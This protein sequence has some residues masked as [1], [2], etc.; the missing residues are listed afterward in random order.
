MSSISISFL[1]KQNKAVFFG[2]LALLLSAGVPA[3]GSDV[4]TYHNDISRTG[5]NLNETILT[6]SNVNSAGFG[7]LFT[8]KVDSDIDAQPLYVSGLTIAGV[9]HN[10]L[11]AVTENDSVYA[12][13]ADTGTQLW[14]VS[15]FLTG[16][17]A[18]QT[19]PLKCNQINPSIGVSE[20]PVIDRSS[21]PNGTIF[22]EAMSEDVA[23]NYYHRL[24]AL[25][26]TTGAELFG[27]PTTIQA[28]YP[29]NGPNSQNGVVTFIP[30][31]YGERSGLLLVNGVIYMGFTS[32]CDNQ[33]YGGW[34]MGY[35]EST[36]AQTSVIGLTPN[37]VQGSIWMA[38]AA[39]ASDGTNI[40]L[41]D[42]NGTFDT[43]LNASGFPTLG[44]YGNAFLK[45]SPSGG[46]NVA[47]YFA[48]YNTALQSEKDRDFGSGGVLL[49]P[50]QANAG[51]TTYNLA[52]GAGKDGNIYVVNQTNM[53][54]FN[55]SSNKIYQEV[56]NVLGS[57]MWAMP[58]YFNGNVYFGPQLGSLKQ[59]TFSKA[60][61]S[62]TAASVTSISYEYPGTIPSISANGTTNGIVWAVEHAVP[63]VLHAYDATNL[64][65][66]LYNSNQA[67]GS[68]DHFGNASHFGVPTISGGK[69]YVGTTKSVAVFGLLGAK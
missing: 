58:A 18:A 8:L 28:Q 10:V 4:L 57:G 34:V 62:T 66:E 56:R 68:R 5:Q 22:V 51:G 1:E 38:G 55:V 17:T 49:L 7:L 47:D 44:D 52:V 63:S 13:D 32:H 39:P 9:S 54:K 48:M 14:K 29:G 42:A 36:L 15:A 40:F 24:H 60:K 33:P 65:T 25:D 50:P 59:F 23:G 35:S 61:L 46:L 2:L 31:D 37:G 43:T 45:L 53:G 16:E 27:G 30:E 3:V 20:T 19:K 26:L 6:T 12:F 67:A 69:V 41:L 64:A 21:G 11:Y